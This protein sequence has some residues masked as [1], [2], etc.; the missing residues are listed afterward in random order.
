M[1]GELL[2]S[3]ISVMHTPVVTMVRYLLLRDTSKLANFIAALACFAE[4][5]RKSRGAR[6]RVRVDHVIAGAAILTGTA[7][8]LIAL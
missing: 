4:V 5:P 2:H 1:H 7:R 8:A 3:S 6:A